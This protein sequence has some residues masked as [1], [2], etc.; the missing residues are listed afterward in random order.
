MRHKYLLDKVPILPTKSNSYKNK[1]PFP[2][3]D[4]LTHKLVHSHDCRYKNRLVN[5]MFSFSLI[6]SSRMKCK[7]SAVSFATAL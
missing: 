4:R 5:C 7:I 1:Q 2:W 3:L 6:T